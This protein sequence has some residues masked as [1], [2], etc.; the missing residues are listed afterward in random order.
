[1]QIRQ[2]KKDD[3]LILELEG[4]LDVNTSNT[5]SDRVLS[6]IGAGEKYFVIDLSQVVYISSSGL[7]AFLT[8]AKKLSENGKIVLSSLRQ[9]VKEIFDISGFGSLFPIVASQEEAL[10]IFQS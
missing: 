8:L 4:R 6:L 9:E 10:R 5:F 3:V 7:R 2:N 1:M